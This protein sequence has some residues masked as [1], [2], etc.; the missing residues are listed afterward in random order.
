[1]AHLSSQLTVTAWKVRRADWPKGEWHVI[2]GTQPPKWASETIPL[3]SLE[4]VNRFL[5]EHGVMAVKNSII[6]ASATIEVTEWPK[7]K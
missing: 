2:G 6:P 5:D 4:D 3:V 7:F 1:M